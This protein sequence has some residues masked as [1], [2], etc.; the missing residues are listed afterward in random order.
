MN[1]DLYPKGMTGYLFNFKELDEKIP[2][3]SLSMSFV[4]FAK[5]EQEA[6]ELVERDMAKILNQLSKRSAE[7]A[8]EKGILSPFTIERRSDENETD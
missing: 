3:N 2:Q 6:I 7:L 4:K 8:G 5:T 1:P